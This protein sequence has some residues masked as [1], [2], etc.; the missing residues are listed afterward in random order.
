M[1]IRDNIHSENKYH[2]RLNMELYLQSLFGLL[3]MAVPRT[4]EYIDVPHSLLK[5]NF[6][7]GTFMVNV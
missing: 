7:A 4:L 3:C 5:C 2:C 6:S 1:C